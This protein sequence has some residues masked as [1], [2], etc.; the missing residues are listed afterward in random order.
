MTLKHLSKS[1]L[2]ATPLLL[3]TPLMAGEA[4]QREELKALQT[5]INALESGQKKDEKRLSSLMQ[6][7]DDKV[8][9]NG[10]FSVG[11]SQHS[12]SDSDLVYAYGQE[13]D[14]SILPNTW[15]GIQMN[16]ELY[17]GAEFVVQV[18]AQGVSGS[19]NVNSG[20]SNESFELRTDWLYFKQ[21]LGAGFSAQ[22]GRIRFPAFTDSEVQYIGN[23]YP[24]VRPPAEIYDVLPISN[25]D[26]V[27]VN[28]QAFVGD[29]TLDTKALLWGESSFNQGNSIISLE[30]TKGVIF[31]ATLD[32][33]NIRFGVLQGEEIIDVNAPA[34]N[35]N[36]NLEPIN[37]QFGDKL[38]WFTSG[39]RFDNNIVYASFEG[40][41]IKSEDDTL[42]ENRNFNITVGGYI[43]NVL[44][45]TGLSK[46]EVTNDDVLGNNLNVELNNQTVLI[47]HPQFGPVPSPV[48]SLFGAF[49]TRKQTNTFIGMKYDISSKTN[50]KAQVQYV[51]DF[52]NSLGNFN[53][54]ADFEDA[55]IF[56]IALQSVF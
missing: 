45:Y 8:K 44:L 53:R 29:W 40:V 55:Y 1:L 14:L 17:E 25:I 50:L 54:P 38:T 24:W 46:I 42:D 28:Y 20:S 48:G 52:E 35:G 37:V 31:S 7:I 4:E 15:V 18:L 22:V 3:S 19:N 39:A 27:S 47:Q 12:E 21:K 30:N 13:S 43:G 34:G 51:D 6:T 49:L 32:A 10:F 36:V 11:L 2:W 16:A 5:R 33:L 23:T 56:D 9:F 26:G 41:L